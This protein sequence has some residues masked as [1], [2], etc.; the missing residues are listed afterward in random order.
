[1]GNGNEYN[2]NWQRIL[3]AAPSAVGSYDPSSDTLDI[4]IYAHQGLITENVYASATSSGISDT[5]PGNVAGY[6]QATWLYNGQDDTAPAEQESYQ[7]FQHTGDIAVDD[8]SSGAVTTGSTAFASTIYPLASVTD[9]RNS[10]G[11]GGSA[12]AT[13]MRGTT[14]PARRQSATSRTS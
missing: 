3:I 7:Y 1:M 13:P 5:T 12:R 8:V 9:Y 2:G 14:C 11:S 10:D 4:A 6:L